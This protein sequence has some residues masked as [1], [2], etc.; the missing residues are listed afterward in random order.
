MKGI[1]MNS[2]LSDL[3]INGKRLWETL[4]TM[5]AIG[6]TPKGGCNR[7]A[8]TDEDRVGRELFMH[9]CKDASCSFRIDQIGNIFARREG[10]SSELPPVMMGSHLDT[11]PTGGKFDGVYG[12]L[13]GVEI[14]R[15]LEENA[16]TTDH[17][18]EVVVWVNEEGS[19]FAPAM[20]GSGVWSG[21]FDFEEMCKTTD[22]SGVSLGSELK[23]LGYQGN[24]HNGP[25]LAK[26]A[27]EAHIE[28]GP[29]LEAEAKQIGVVTGVQGLRWY[30]LV[31]KGEP[32]HAGPP[33]MESR[34]DP[35]TGLLP[36]LQ[37]CYDLAAKYAPW[38]RVTFGDIRAEPGSRNT[39]PERLFV[40]IDMRHPDAGVLDSMDEAFRACVMKECETR[41][42][43]G[44]VDELWHMPAT[45]F[46]EECVEAVGQA[47]DR[48]GYSCMEIVSGAGHDSVQI[49]TVVPT[50]MIFVPCEGGI[51]HN[52]AENAK[53]EDLE[54]GANV[55]LHA[56][57]KMAQHHSN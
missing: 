51:S 30:D 8:M 41:G 53:P 31:I 6:G 16:I 37:Q 21:L 36:I 27:F 22:K 9:W 42:L 39:V 23:R 54:A 3:R 24:N 35:F 5:G 56:V 7:Q 13:A 45:V 32:C 50:A 49:S 14:L 25:W 38:G 12:V 20:M 29:I 17:P 2:N 11:Q 28:Q 52:E 10:Q 19:R 57:L 48:L 1:S 4:M 15:T 43:E 47:T 26:A 44:S 18:I 55:L 34:R 40:N 33:P 46:A